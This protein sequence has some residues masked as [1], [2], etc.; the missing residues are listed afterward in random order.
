MPQDRFVRHA[1]F[2]SAL[3]IISRITGLVRDKLCS[4][5]IGVDT[6]WAA[7]WMGFQFPNLFR[8]IFGE[9]ALTAVFVPA[10]TQLLEKEGQ[11]KATRLANATLTLLFIVLTGA[12]LVGEAILIP[13]AL[14]SSVL[15][16]NRL[17]ATMIAIML[18]YCVLVCI[19]ALMGA[20]GT[21]HE[22]FAA[23]SLSPIILNLFM[24]GAAAAAVFFMTRA[25]PLQQRI[26]WVAFAV[27]AAGVLQVVMMLPTL[28]SSGIKLRP[29]FDFS[30]AGI[31]SVIK[32]M[33]P[34]AVGY[35]AVQIN[36]FMDTQIAWW[37]SPDGHGGIAHFQ[38]FGHL[39]PVAMLSGAAAK[40]SIAQRIYLLPVG[41]FGVSMATAIFPPMS[42]AAADKNHAE[43]KRLLVAGLK[44]TLFLSIPASLGMALIAR[45]LITLVYLGGNVTPE[46][47]DRATHAAVFFCLGIW[48][49][50]MQMVI[51][52]V[53]FALGDTTTPTRV[54]LCMIVLNFLLNLTLVWFLQEGGI[55][56]ATTLAAVIQSGVLLLI[57]RR[58]LGALGTKPL[59]ISAAMG[60][61]VTAVMTECGY[62]L[63]LMPAPWEPHGILIADP[64]TRVKAR[65]LS[66]LVKLPLIVACCGAIYLAL[67]RFLGAPEVEEMP[68]VGRFLRKRSELS[69]TS[70]Q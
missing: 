60:L 68:F 65:L 41:I 63:T 70:G 10:Y 50:E 44:K 47:V 2:M 43:L 25:Y 27:L 23:Q 36:T 66:A 69:A 20:I 53:Y 22:K 38:F 16:P 39:L 45:P 5:F 6:T 30:G 31:A 33:I 17:A 58:R 24:A 37:L 61:L 7:F 64:A 55:A 14:S 19:V 8:R 11:E 42:R 29:L 35:S 40:L 28:F 12:T 32:P 15:P 52:R 21:V 9:G 57:L 26:Y 54:A 56:L 48:A 4:Y 62:L 46:D 67:M 13:I 1:N 49:F 18:P 3:T 59:L 51:A 34:I